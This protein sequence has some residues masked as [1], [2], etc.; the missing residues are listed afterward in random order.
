MKKL[1]LKI[2]FALAITISLIG[3]NDD[4]D[5]PTIDACATSAG[6]NPSHPKA[7]AFQSILDRYVQRGLPGLVL[8]IKTPEGIWT[9]AAGKA[10]IETGEFMRPCNLIYS[11]SMAKTFTAVSIMKL[12]EEGRI[13]LDAPI[14]TYLP[15]AICNRIANA[16]Q[17]TVR[18]LLNHR[19]G[20]RS[21]TDEPEYLSELV[22]N[23]GQNLTVQKNLEYIYDKPALFEPGT[24]FSYSNTPY[25]LLG[26]IIDQVTGTNHADFFTNR[27]FRPLG[28]TDIY[29]RDATPARIIDTYRDLGNGELTNVSV[30]EK[31]VL[32]SQYGAAGILSLASNYATFIEAIFRGNLISPASRA[33]MTTWSGNSTYGLGLMRRDSPYG[34]GIGH[35]GDGLGCSSDMFYFP[36]SGVTIV[37]ET[38]KGPATEADVELYRVELWNEVVRVAT[39]N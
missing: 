21:Y 14:T 20:I 31:R 33:A 24:S 12:V 18:Q 36:D 15:A 32:A 16:H 23:L 3:C 17:A 2:T 19:S 29:Y 39:G 22:D 34:Y 25:Q 10:S 5:E 6:V 37:M 1:I 7:T 28:L 9:G 13:S 8:Y 30:V 35:E 26:M 27:I 38:N 4:N 11:Q